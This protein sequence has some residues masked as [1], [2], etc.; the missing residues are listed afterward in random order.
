MRLGCWNIQGLNS[1]QQIVTQELDRYKMDITILTETKKKGAGTEDTGNY[2]LLYS[3]MEKHKRAKAGVAI[4]IRKHLGNKIKCWNPVNERI[5][6]TEI[7]IGSKTLV[8]IGAYSPTDDS[9]VEEKEHFYETLKNEIEKVKNKYEVVLM[10]DLNART[11]QKIGSDI[12]GQ[13]GEDVTNDNGLR[14]I[15]TCEE[16]SLKIMNGFFP[17]KSI[18][19]YTWVQPTRNL[20]SVID[21]FILKQNSKIKTLDVV[22]KRG[23]E[24]EQIIFW[25]RQQ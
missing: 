2:I 8:I 22:V 24:I 10:G 19:K 21:Y 17:H 16:C 25:L 7:E 23:A 5:I 18:H 9:T 13:Y 4:V 14:L 1:K 6:T 20:R 12:V 3:G 15:E 11:G